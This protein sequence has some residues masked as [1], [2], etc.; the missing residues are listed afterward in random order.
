MTVYHS[1]SGKEVQS[2]PAPEAMDGVN[3][4]ANLK[5]IYMTGGRWYGT[6]EASAG[7][8]YVYQQKDCDHYELIFKIK[9]RPGSGTSLLAPQFKR[10]YVA[11]QAIDEQD[12]AILVFEPVPRDRR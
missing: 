11:S 10:L 4:D 6:P 5:R 9:T 1:V 7:W 2:L 3:Y 8:V 12:A